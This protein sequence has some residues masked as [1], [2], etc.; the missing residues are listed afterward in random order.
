MNECEQLVESGWFKE[1]MA[2]LARLRKQ[3]EIARRGLDSASESFDGWRKIAKN[4]LKEMEEV[5]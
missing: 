5:K 4:T 1:R 3:L 2:E